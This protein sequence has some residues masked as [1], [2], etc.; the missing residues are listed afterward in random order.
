MD[1]PKMFNWIGISID[2]KTMS[3]VPNMILTKDAILC[4]LNVN[5]STKKSILWLKRKLKSFLMNNVTIYFR[6]DITSKEYA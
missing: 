1:D 2:T 6:P 4:S 3:M 5:I